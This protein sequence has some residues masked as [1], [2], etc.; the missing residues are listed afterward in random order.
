[1]L[2][3][4]AESNVADRCGKQG[5][6]FRFF[7]QRI[8]LMSI[9]TMVNVIGHHL[10]GLCLGLT[11]IFVTVILRLISFGYFQISFKMIWVVSRGPA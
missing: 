8:H 3:T 4:D 9:S 2:L 11:K 5:K 1:M 6:G 10:K 7:L